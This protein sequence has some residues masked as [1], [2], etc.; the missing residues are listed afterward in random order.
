M[1]RWTP[2]LEEFP[3]HLE[4]SIRNWK[5]M[6][7]GA[8]LQR[9]ISYTTFQGVACDNKVSEIVMHVIN[10]GTYHR[11]QIR[12]IAGERGV[13]FPETDYIRFLRE[14]AGLENMRYAAVVEASM[15]PTVT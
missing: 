12:G 10:H 9:M 4:C 7:L 8:D 6:I 2:T 1:P 15:A 3:M 5:R 13:E 14:S 11:G